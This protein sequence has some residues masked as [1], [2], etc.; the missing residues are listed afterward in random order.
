MDDIAHATGVSRSTVSFVLNGREDIQIPAPTRDR[1]R[2]AARELGY[3]PHAG[4]QALAKAR[5]DL[6]G[7]VTDIVATP[8]AGEI[9]RGAQHAAWAR[10]KFLLVV[11]TDG[12]PTRVAAAFE[13]LLQRRVE[14]IIFA[15]QANESVTL[16]AAAREVPTVLVHCVS[17]AGDFTTILP[18]EEAGGALATETLI[19]AGHRRIGMINLD[20]WLR[21]AIPRETG[22]R[23]ALATAGVAFNPR[24]VRVGH[25]TAEGGYEAA[26]ELLAEV[27]PPT[28]LFCA[29]DRMAMG[30]YDAVK[31]AGLRIPGDV[32]VVGFDNQEIIAAFLRPALTTVALPFDTMGA[33]AIDALCA[34]SFGPPAVTIV[35]CPLVERASVGR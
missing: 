8:F 32:S 2:A 16:P 20:P 33:T 35:P 3:R 29:N 30:A 11:G 24:L 4:A 12:D 21:A 19:R 15:T 34:P 5:T 7:I 23:R 14:G 13:M 9:I 17:D 22:Y 1:V 26:R 18:D 10:D 6:I 28:A 25:A 31:E 27:D